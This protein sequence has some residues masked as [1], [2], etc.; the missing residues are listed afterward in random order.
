VSSALI[1][2]YEINSQC[3][4]Y[5]TTFPFSIIVRYP[6][7]VRMYCSLFVGVNLSHS[8]IEVI[9]STYSVGPSRTDIFPKNQNRRKTRIAVA[10]ATSKQQASRNR[11]TSKNNKQQPQLQLQLLAIDHQSN[12]QNHQR[13]SY[14]HKVKRGR[15]H[16]QDSAGICSSPSSSEGLF[17]S[18]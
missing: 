11:R 2:L 4:D 13:V 7:Y 6:W 8:H 16:S 5:R 9:S 14:G 12:E 17:T 1:K 15:K 18:Q 3:A 10:S